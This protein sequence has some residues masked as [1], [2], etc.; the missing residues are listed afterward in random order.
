[1]T[2]NFSALEMALA[3]LESAL[4]PPPRN[5]RERDGAIHRFEYIFE[6][7]WKTAKNCLKQSG[8]DSP[9]PKSVI[10]DMGQ[11]K[12]I[13]VGRRHNRPGGPPWIP[14]AGEYVGGVA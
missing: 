5:D 9:S 10:R 8:I 11:Q 14:A 13:S 7:C 4:T 6:L 2:V 1:M 12:W 3:S